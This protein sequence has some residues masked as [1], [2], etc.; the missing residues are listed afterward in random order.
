MTLSIHE[1]LKHLKSG[2]LYEDMSGKIIQ[3][4][5]SFCSLFDISATSSEIEGKDSMDVWKIICNSAVHADDFDWCVN[6][7]S[8]RNN[9]RNNELML[10]NGRVIS[11]HYVPVQKN[12]KLKGRLWQYNDVTEI[13]FKE[14]RFRLITDLGFLLASSLTMEDSARAVL[15]TVRNIEEIDCAGIYMINKDSGMVELI[16]SNGASDGFLKKT[17]KYDPSMQQFKIVMKG[18]TLFGPYSEIISNSRLFR[19]ENLS[20][21]GIIP[22]KDTK[23]RVTGCLNVATSKQEGFDDEVKCSLKYIT[24]KLGETIDRIKSQNA[25]LVSCNSFQSFF[26]SIDNFL[27]ILDNKGFILKFNSFVETQLGYTEEELQEMN[28]LDLFYS[29]IKGLACP[30]IN[31]G[32]S[33]SENLIDGTLTGKHC[34]KIPVQAKLARGIWEGNDVLYVICR[35]ISEK[36]EVEEKLRN[37][38]ARWQFA[39]EGCGDGLWDWNIKNNSVFYSKQWKKMFGYEENDILSQSRRD[40]DKYIHPDD[41]ENRDKRLDLHL[42]GNS[43]LYRSEHRIL[44]KNRSYKWVLVRGKVVT[45]DKDG[46][47]ERIIGITID[48]EKRKQL[49]NSLR[50]SL[51][52]EKELN[53]LK[54][55]FVSKAS[56][57]FRTPLS[58]ML[59]AA[60]SLGNYFDSMTREARAK[61][62][63]RIKKNIKF[64]K[65]VIEKVLD[66]SHLDSGRI[67]FRPE[68]TN[69]NEFIKNI[70]TE[71]RT[72]PGIKHQVALSLLR[73]PVSVFID[74]QMIRQVL[75]NILSNSFKY[76]PELSAV[77]VR[78]KIH[79]S[80]A[81]ISISDQ[82]IGIAEEDSKKIFE[83]FFRGSNVGDV[84]GSGLGL[85]LAGK[86][87]AYNGGDISFTSGSSG[88]TTF[89]V[90]LRLINDSL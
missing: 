74:K 51:Q 62:I 26:E 53:E 56:H 88:G 36:I 81:V 11:Y 49:E 48:I 8:G 6:A 61:K 22:V 50:D 31:S 27:F 90:K 84:K 23:G 25:F 43:A 64:L 72:I 58:V 44:C 32:N 3:V 34:N 70:I 75:Y 86:F 47:P 63:N 28:I 67:Q 68:K 42:N 30:V 24:L 89:L 71:T 5:K 41:L 55:L 40:A 12:G 4:N 66:L 87:V 78:L 85:A 38:E 82:G 33:V 29:E 9:V 37:S 46:N 79:K 65:N 83:P 13:R 60:E 21:I 1:L 20:C 7:M 2:I 17:Q 52:K 39:L 69:L 19:D 35:D 45:R 59:F 76:S 80:Q 18:K 14:K 10:K 73:Q 77:K 54:S 15:E 16:M 57:E